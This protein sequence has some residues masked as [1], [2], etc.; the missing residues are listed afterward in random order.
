MK[1]CTKCKESKPL[2]DFPSDK[3]RKD[4]LANKCRPCCYEQW[5]SW[6]EKN[7]EHSKTYQRNYRSANPEK[8]KEWAERHKKPE[9]GK[10]AEYTRRWT[11]K[12][13]DRVKTYGE[14]YRSEN[15]E[16]LTAYARERRRANPI[17]ERQRVMRH[18]ALK[19]S[20]A[21]GKVDYGEIVKRDE[22]ICYLCESPIDMTLPKGHPMTL[23]FDH[24]IPLSK[25]GPHSME[26]VRTT[27]ARCNFKKGAR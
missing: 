18:K 1:T 6:R 24:V 27:H 3:S 14:R 11:Q 7:L 21:V 20:N 22:G 16:R 26:N 25:G 8:V 5:K 13:Q 12:N 9:P 4:G 23:S 10:S 2:S 17:A 15:R 19:R